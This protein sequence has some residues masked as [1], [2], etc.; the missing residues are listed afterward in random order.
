MSVQELVDMFR[1]VYPDVEQREEAP[2]GEVP[3]EGAEDVHNT[4]PS[5]VGEVFTIDLVV[6]KVLVEGNVEGEKTCKEVQE[7][8]DPVNEDP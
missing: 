2:D 3:S 7:E 5:E 4:V 6:P 1:H 8:G